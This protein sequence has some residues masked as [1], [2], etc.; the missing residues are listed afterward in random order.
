MISTNRQEREREKKY[1][2]YLIRINYIKLLYFFPHEFFFF[3]SFF[4]SLLCKIFHSLHSYTLA[5]WMN[6]M[7]QSCGQ[8]NEK[9][10]YCC[11]LS[12]ATLNGHDKI[13]P[14]KNVQATKDFFFLSL[15]F[16]FC[17][18][19]L[20]FLKCLH[21]SWIISKGFSS[22]F[23]LLK[24]FFVIYKEIV[25]YMWMWCVCVNC[26]NFFCVCV[27]IIIIV[28][29]LWSTLSILGKKKKKERK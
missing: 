8:I 3:F 29:E 21:Q 14:S 17:N 24:F 26:D 5:W 25:Y 1:K 9:L 10:V 27:F 22:S 28:A 2:K 4:P 19:N 7:H 6:K 16:I 18:L 13:S 15:S 23:I 20:L 11:N 12:C